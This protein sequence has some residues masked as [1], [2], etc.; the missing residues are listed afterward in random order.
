MYTQF[1]GIQKPFQLAHSVVYMAG[2]S[3]TTLHKEPW[4][5]E[6]VTVLTLAQCLIGPTTTFSVHKV[7]CVAIVYVLHC[8]HLHVYN[9][10]KCSLCMYFTLLPLFSSVLVQGSVYQHLRDIGPLN[11][12]L[13][14]KYTRQI[15]EGVAYLHDNR[16]VHRDVKGANILRGS[17]GNIKLA[18]FGAS[19]RLQVLQ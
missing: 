13:A 2:S 1:A 9:D 6:N 12:I 11:E 19:K 18:D 4:F 8:V 16:I 14:R 5:Q 7:L 10:M 3:T 15:L 17:F